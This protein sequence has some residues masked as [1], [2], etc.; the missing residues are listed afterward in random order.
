[1]QRAI[2]AGS[3]S[4]GLLNV[5]VKIYKGNKDGDVHFMTVHSVCH[6]A[7]NTKKWCN[8]CNKEVTKE[9]MLKGFKISKEQTVEFHEK[10]L[11]AIAVQENKQIK[12]EK[13]VVSGELP[14]AG[15]DQLY[16]LQPDKFAEHAYS[17]L[18]KGLS[19]RNLALIG[20]LIMRSKEHLVAI[21]S[22]EGGLALI[23]LHWPDEVNSIK[24][25]IT[26]L[27][28]VPDEELQLATMLI[29]RLKQPLALEGYQDTYRAK[30]EAMI[31]QRLSG[32]TMVVPQIAAPE[33][34]TNVMDALK[35][36]L[37][38]TQQAPA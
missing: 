32:E 1:M 14:L 26:S 9:E 36:S 2:A 10:E 35:Q 12:I 37:Q 7:V 38:L 27:D 20:R 18:A 4:L 25:L 6:G 15:F 33:P 16:F 29:D 3:I 8:K 13:A 11:E 34:K 19:T 31:Q 5:P 30:L 17:L 22:Y 21:T 28:P 24:P 23:T